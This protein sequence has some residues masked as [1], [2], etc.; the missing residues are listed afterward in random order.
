MAWTF[1][2]RCGML[3]VVSWTVCIFFIYFLNVPLTAM[4]QMGVLEGKS[5]L[6]SLRA[7]RNWQIT[8][9]PKGSISLVRKGS[10]VTLSQSQSIFL[11][12]CQEWLCLQGCVSNMLNAPL[13]ITFSIGW[14]GNT[15]RK[16]SGPRKHFEL[17]L[18]W[19]QWLSSAERPCSSCGSGPPGAWHTVGTQSFFLEPLL[20]PIARNTEAPLISSVH[21]SWKPPACKAPTKALR[22]EWYTRQT[23]PCSHVP[24]IPACSGC[25]PSLCLLVFWFDVHS[26]NWASVLWIK[27]MP[28]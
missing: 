7:P 12:F 23:W 25:C 2:L 6:F 20:W 17:R 10:V 5:L 9:Y 14:W 26:I 1:S 22:V 27:F 8:P 3:I 24:C 28:C 18:S 13:S 21:I 15:P 4:C 11:V 16:Y 19:W